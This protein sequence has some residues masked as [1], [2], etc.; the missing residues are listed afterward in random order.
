MGKEFNDKATKQRLTAAK[1]VAYTNR[2][3]C[4]P[5]LHKSFV[6]QHFCM[7]LSRSTLK[8]LINAYIC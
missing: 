8:R 6:L 4:Y 7:D 2:F 5:L 1:R 3:A